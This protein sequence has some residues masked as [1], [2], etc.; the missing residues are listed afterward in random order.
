MFCKDPS[1]KH[2][3]TSI[4]PTDAKGGCDFMVEPELVLPNGRKVHP[5]D[6]EIQT[7]LTKSLGPLDE[8]KSQLAVT[9]NSG[10]NCVHFTPIQA[11]SQFSKS[12]YSIRDHL[13]FENSKFIKIFY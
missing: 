4:D 10:Y 8:W 1:F 6:L 7:C 9:A 2:N 12:S 5:N 11:L 13:R 3:V